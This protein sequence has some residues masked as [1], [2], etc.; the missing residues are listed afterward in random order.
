[1]VTDQ[2]VYNLVPGNLKTYKRR[3]PIKQLSAITLSADSDDF[4]LHVINHY[5]YHFRLNRRA[6]AVHII[7][8]QFRA[9]TGE[10]LQIRASSE[11]DLPSIILTKTRFEEQQQVERVME[12][13]GAADAPLAS[14]R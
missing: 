9:L 12:S 3:I 13:T 1:M 5:D 10:E 6:V 11:G 2:A 14:T 8:K 4:V 7:S